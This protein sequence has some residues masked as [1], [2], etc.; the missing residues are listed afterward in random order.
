MRS[1]TKSQRRIGAALGYANIAVKNIVNLI[2][3]PML[4]SFVGQADYGVYQSCNSFVFSLSLLSFGF[5][6]A[7]VKF[8]TTE[9]IGSGEKGIYRL[10]GVYLVLYT[11]VSLLALVLGLILASNA[12]II[13]SNGFS[14]QEV[15]LAGSVM[16][17]MSVNIA[18]T[19]FT[20]ISDSYILAHEEFGFQQTRQLITTLAT[21]LI[22]LI[23]LMF[24]M[25]ALGVAIAQLAISV[26]L[27]GL[28]F[29]YAV[30]NL[31]M[32][33]ELHG[34]NR[35]LFS[36]IAVF[37]SWIFINQACDLVNQNV[38]NVLLGM[39]TNATVVSV[40]AV[41]VQI[42]NVF[43]SLSTT[44]SNVFT[45]RIN[46]IVA[47]SND[48]AV[49][50]QLMTR[51]GRYQMIL[52]CWVYGGFVFLGEFFVTTW[53]GPGFTDAYWLIVAMVFPLVIPLTQNTG[54]E[55]QRAKNMHRARSVAMLVAAVGNVVI[56]LL[57][58]PSIGF[59]APAVGYI[60]SITLC[61]GLF[62]NWYYQKRVGLDMAYFWRKNLPVV[63]ASVVVLAVC[64]LAKHVA[65]VTGWGSFLTWGL[66]YSTLFAVAI[67]VSVL[68]PEERASIFARLPISRRR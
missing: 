57:T 5:S 2:Y 50:T 51:V 1:T 46:Q 17:V 67:G 23:L 59:W 35:R 52:F 4:L 31:G 36:S 22:A 60:L 10:N 53:A 26:L 30:G 65:P 45:P 8:Y 43:Y 63:F 32:R 19:L 21:P 18:V 64:L 11:A 54:I 7:Y 68:S 61:N 15:M 66:A 62:M 55:I 49:L 28:N 27:L 29:R 39:L 41:S 42:R 20:S 44:M 6:T 37:S 3:T 58:A 16:S 13:F 25:G 40:F 24:G 38:P 12:E 9:K 56:T 33:F 14:A 34:L 47:E 48:N